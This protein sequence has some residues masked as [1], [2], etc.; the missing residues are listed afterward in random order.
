[1]DNKNKSEWIIVSCRLCGKELLYP[2]VYENQLD[3]TWECP[4]CKKKYKNH[5]STHDTEATYT[6]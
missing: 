3:S 4:E 2:K 5:V 1:M 6:T